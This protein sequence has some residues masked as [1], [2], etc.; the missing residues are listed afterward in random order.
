MGQIGLDYFVGTSG[1]AYSWNLKKSLDWF[2]EN[3]G[4]NAIELNSSYYHFPSPTSVQTWSQKSKN[5]RWSIKVNRLFT[6]TYRF[7]QNAVERWQ[8]F[9]ELFSPLNDLVDF[10]LFQ[11]PP[12]ITP[13]TAP[14]IESFAKKTNLKGRFALEFRN[15]EWFK[16]EWVNW[17]IDLGVTLVSV[18]APDLPRYIFNTTDRVYLRMHG[19]TTWYAHQYNE[20]ELHEVESK[21]LRANPEKAYVFFNNDHAMPQNAKSMLQILNRKKQKEKML[22]I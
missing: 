4:L 7:N 14:L 19:R 6:H 8:S 18:D 11:M 1:W 3:T 20:N 2:M 22:K 15:Q 9:Y 5:L 17:A 16:N 21:I 13:K 10:Y 12:S